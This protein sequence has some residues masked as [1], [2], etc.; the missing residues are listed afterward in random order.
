MRRIAG[1]L[2]VIAGACMTLPAHAQS[3]AVRFEI[4]AIGDSTIE[5]RTSTSKWIRPGQLGVAVDP[6]RRDVLIARFRVE[7]VKEGSALA[8]ITGQT[9]AVTL[10]HV[11]VLDEPR[12]SAYA[13]PAFWIGIAVGGAL[14]FIG[15]MAAR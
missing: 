8:V 6:R 11:A 9:T 4:T 3:R 7:L 14:G 10:E 5:F 2:L 1:A 13:S 15:G 12:R